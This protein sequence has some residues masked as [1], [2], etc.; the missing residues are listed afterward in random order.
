MMSA[1]TASRSRSACTFA[2]VR[3]K[4]WRSRLTPPTSIAAPITRRTLPRMEPTRDAFTTSCSP[5]LSAK[6][7]MM[8]S[9]AFP[10]VTFRKPPIPGPERAASSSVARPMSAAVGMTPRAEVMNTSAADAC[11]SSSAM[12][13]G[14]KGTRTYGQPSPL[15]RKRRNEN[16][17]RE[18]AP[19]DMAPEPIGALRRGGGARSG[20]QQRGALAGGRRVRAGARDAVRVPLDLRPARAGGARPGPAARPAERA[21]PAQPDAERSKLPG[22]FVE[23]PCVAR[24]RD[25]LVLVDAGERQVQLQAARALRRGRADVDA[26]P[27]QDAVVLAGVE[28]DLRLLDGLLG[29]AALRGRELVG[30]LVGA[31]EPERLPA[32]QRVVEVV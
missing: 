19:A 2:A 6:K 11:V 31:L 18:G 7:A 26:E 14:M 10:N 30:Q 9:G 20:R 32:V 13:I 28:L 21:E 4:Y 16:R 29:L 12:A 23:R 8:S 17:P 24:G 27:A 1:P 3:S 15:M 5:S 25:L 22:Q